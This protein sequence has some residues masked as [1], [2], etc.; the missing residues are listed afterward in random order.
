ML[1]ILTLALVV[2]AI[3][4][5]L[6]LV[7]LILYLSKKAPR[8]AKIGV[9]DE[10]PLYQS[11]HGGACESDGPVEK[12]PGSGRQ[13]LRQLGLKIGTL[14]TGPENAITDVSGVKVGHV[15]VSHGEGKLTPGNGPARTGVTAI[16]PHEG[17]VWNDRV[18]AAVYV[19]NGNG[20]LTGIDWIR[21]SGTLEV[22]VVLTNTL[23]VGTVYDAV[24]SWMLKKYPQIGIDDD[25][26]IPVVGE[27]D[28]SVLNDIQGRHVKEDHVFSALNLAA[29]G[30]VP[31][32][33]VGAGTGMI[34]YE[35]KGGI[36]TAS[37]V[38]PAEDGGYTVG[39]LVNCN[40]GSRQQLLIDGVPVGAEIPE[41]LATE[42]REG[43]IVVVI[44]TDAP[45]T[46]RQLGR[47]CR[48]AA[49]GLARTGSVAQ[50]ESGDF[51]LAF[52][53]SRR[54]PRY[55]LRDEASLF[56]Y[57]PELSNSNINPLFEA[58]G[59]AT[60][61]AIANALCMAETMIGRDSNVAHALP[62]D[63]LLEVFRKHGK[64][65]MISR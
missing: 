58:A 39:V 56:Y 24:I 44:A 7:R 50:H 33:S 52:S 34:C 26:C 20:V 1:E 38:L 9:P 6:W 48:R 23:S 63:R 40:H 51:F 31:E 47:L 3:L 5:V 46:P 22:P 8:G 15:T 57:L 29:G 10:S 36:G 60:G 12:F 55:I 17:D 27:C 4:L 18:S 43:S 62:L 13:R 37:R 49:L 54:I 16:I 32:G 11:A 59:E 45:L 28:D 30:R 25:T 65:I 14:D 21:E 61:E 53:T 19:L 42:H 35:F 41:D 2:P 64:A